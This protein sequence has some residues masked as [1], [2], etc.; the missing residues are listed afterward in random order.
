VTKAIIALLRA[1]Y[2]EEQLAPPCRTSEYM[3]PNRHGRGVSPQ[4]VGEFG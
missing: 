2:A 4:L 3:R 1:E